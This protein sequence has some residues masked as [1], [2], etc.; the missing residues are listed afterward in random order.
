[1]GGWGG[2]DEALCVGRDGWW[3]T[4][5]GTGRIVSPHII[6]PHNVSHHNI[7]FHQARCADPVQASSQVARI[8]SALGLRH[9]LGLLP[10]TNPHMPWAQTFPAGRRG[11]MTAHRPP[12]TRS[13][14]HSH[15]LRTTP[16]H[17][18]RGVIRPGTRVPNLIPSQAL[19]PQWECR[20]GR[21]A[22]QQQQALRRMELSSPPATTTRTL[23]KGVRQ[24]SKMQAQR[25]VPLRLHALCSPWREG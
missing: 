12:R 5:G 22:I 16:P 18:G 8:N 6:S 23:G 15:R 14:H 21:E 11:A 1:M 20:S 17:C 10:N 3:D 2:D 7:S 24:Q 25:S 19:A 13:R 9:T 4:E